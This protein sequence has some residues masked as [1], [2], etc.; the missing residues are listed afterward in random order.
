M[1][2]ET[3]EALKDV[4]IIDDFIAGTVA[5]VEHQVRRWGT[6]HDRGKEH[7]DW[8]W[9]IGYL[10]GKALSAAKAGNREKALHHT[11]STAAALFNWHSAISGNPTPMMPGADMAERKSDIAAA[12]DANFPGETA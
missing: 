10:A 4:P 1:N 6:A 12:V 5:E 9:L 11:I 3:N 7:E 2:T 8:F